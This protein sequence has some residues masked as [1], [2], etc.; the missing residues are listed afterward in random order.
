M[1]A[2]PT[3]RRFD[4]YVWSN[5]NAGT[6]ALGARVWFCRQG[7]TANLVADLALVPGSAVTLAVYSTGAVTVGDWVIVDGNPINYLVVSSV[8]VALK[9]IGATCGVVGFTLSKHSRM[10]PVMPTTKNPTAIICDDPLGLLIGSQP[11][12]V[13]S[14]GRVATYVKDYR[15]D[16][17]IDLITGEI[18][19]IWIDQEG[20][21]VMRT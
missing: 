7:A 5:V 10:T 6:P 8:D 4:T 21:F 18:N 14:Y 15:Y 13:N 17:Y 2:V 19:R 20:S 9:Q 11:L 12:I 1:R 16:Y 3:L